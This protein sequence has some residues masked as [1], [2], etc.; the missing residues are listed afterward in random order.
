MKLSRLLES[1]LLYKMEHQDDPEILAI[2]MD[3]RNVTK[4]SL[5]FCIKGERFDGH[6]YA[7][8]VVSKGAV[9]LVAEH[10]LDVNVPVIIVNNVRRTMSILADRFYGYPTHDISLIGVTGTN[11]KTTVTHLIKAIQD[12][13]GNDTGIIGTLGIKYK[14]VE[15]KL[16]NTTPEAPVLQKAFRQMVDGGVKSA[17]MEV[18][19]HA[20]VQ[21]RVRG[22]DY[23]IAVFTNLTQDHLDY[24]KTMEEYLHA[25]SLLFS[26][27]GNTYDTKHIKAAVINNDDPASARLKEATA[28]PV[29][30][31]GIDKEADFMARNIRITPSG[32]QF[33]LCSPGEI[34]TVNMKMIGKFNVY[35]VLA[36][37]VACC[38]SGL[39]LKEIIQTVEK[40]EGV[41]GRF[42]T[43]DAGQ[44]F[45]VIVDYSHTP[46]SLENVLQAIHEFAEKR[47]ITVVGCG[48]DRDKTKRPI[49]AKVAVDHSD[50]A[51]FTSDNPRT[52]DPDA[53]ISDMEKGV[54]EGSYIKITDRREAITKAIQEAEPGDIILIAGKGHETY[55]IIGSNVVDFDDRLVARQAIKEFNHGDQC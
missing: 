17:V 41:S 55:Q 28:S 10:T 30:T 38:L 31:Y 13:H 44:D 34:A 39:S 19:S 6:E 47:V 40:I 16:N 22:C 35:N 21:G 2:E 51:I 18:S 50:I 53:I 36:T 8:D 5:F 4:G 12:S 26:Q 52:E 15:I 32:T 9:A 48:G 14:D 1:T 27:L 49:M 37:T 7:Q 11:G 25:K 23:N 24:H 45:T 33:E 46:D 20:L 54:P 3:N 29:W 42:E 43:V